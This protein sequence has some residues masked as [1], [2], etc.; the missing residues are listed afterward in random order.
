MK[1]STFCI[2]APIVVAAGILGSNGAVSRIQPRPSAYN[3]AVNDALDCT[4][5]V[6]AEWRADHRSFTWKDVHDEVCRR[7]KV[8]RTEPWT[9]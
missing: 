4:L 7:L 8:K 2:L 1:F 6:G 3:Q 9:R 5:A